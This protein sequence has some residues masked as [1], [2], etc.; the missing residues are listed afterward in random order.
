MGNSELTIRAGKS[1]DIEAV[2]RFWVEAA[3]GTDR[4]DDPDKV[5]Q[6]V[7]R[8]PEAL[9]VAELEGRMVGTLIAGWDGWRAHLYRLAVAPGHRR[10]GIGSR[11]I[12]AAEARFRTFGAFRADAMV[13]DDN[14]LAHHAWSASGYA[15]QPQWGRWV[16]PLD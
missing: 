12:A 11:L 4:H 2:L 5:V 14:T 15:R 6:L 10:M 13:L 3:E 16:K 7:E 1:D 8:D 9:L